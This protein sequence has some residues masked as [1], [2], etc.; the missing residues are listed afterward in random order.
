MPD[1]GVGPKSQEARADLTLADALFE[2]EAAVCD[3]FPSLNPFS[4][5]REPLSEFC[6]L[7]VKVRGMNG[8]AKRRQGKDGKARIRRPAGDNWFRPLAI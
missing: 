4:I 8:R 5:R 2:A 1:G 6:A 7:L 3:R